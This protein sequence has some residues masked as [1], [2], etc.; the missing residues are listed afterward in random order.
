MT[1]PSEDTEQKQFLGMIADH[2]EIPLKLARLYCQNGHERDDLVQEIYGQLWRSFPKYDRSRSFS[3]WMYRVALNVSISFLRRSTRGSHSTLS[4]EEESIQVI[5]PKV[6][7]PDER[8]AELER[9]MATL[10]QLNRA[11]LML[12]LDDQSHRE[13]ALILGISE[14]NVGTKIGRLKKRIQKNLS[15]NHSTSEVNYGTKRL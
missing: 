6:D 13:I 7:E 12:Y 2:Q 1:K 14:S 11:L 8:L 5:T 3:T 15:T 9:F 10:D 4:L